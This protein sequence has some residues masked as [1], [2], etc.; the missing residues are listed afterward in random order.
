MGISSIAFQC[1]SSIF[2]HLLY[3]MAKNDRGIIFLKINETKSK[4][5]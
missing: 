1:F 3:Q 5:Q 2:D 4:W